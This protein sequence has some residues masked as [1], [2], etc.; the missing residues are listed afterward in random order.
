MFIIHPSKVPEVIWSGPSHG[1]P[2]SILVLLGGPWIVLVAFAARR[3]R[4]TRLLSGILL[5]L[6]VSGLLLYCHS[7]PKVYSSGA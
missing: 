2:M 6:L 3:C 1:Y 4:E 5:C 7:D